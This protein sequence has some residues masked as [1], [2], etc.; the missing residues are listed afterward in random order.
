MSEPITV[1]VADDQTAIREALA[2]MLDLVP[3]IH[4]VA[5]AAN[6]PSLEMPAAADLESAAAS[7][8]LAGILPDALP[9]AI[10]VLASSGKP[11][12]LAY[13]AYSR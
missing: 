4:V 3:D 13:W 8:S 11:R 10:T 5:S 9:L 7:E 12:S 1:V 6:E 2:T